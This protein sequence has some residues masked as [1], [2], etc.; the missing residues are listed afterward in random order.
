MS[1]KHKVTSIV[2]F[3][4]QFADIEAASATPF[5]LSLENDS[6]SDWVDAL[7]GAD[8]V[9]FAAGAGGKG[10]PDRTEAVDYKGAL[11]VFDAIEALHDPKPR[12]VLVSAVDIRD[13]EKIPDHY[14]RIAF[15][16]NL[17]PAC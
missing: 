16:S 10:T 17:I 8:V 3:S 2:R 6:L 15:G 9:V 12:L 14:V 7:Q 13:P 11:K 4:N 1:K 5:H